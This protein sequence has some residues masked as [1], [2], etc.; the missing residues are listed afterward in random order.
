MR[1]VE[2]QVDERGGGDPGDERADRAEPRDDAADRA[3]E[4]LAPQPERALEEDDPDGDR[5]RV[6]EGGTEERLRVDQLEDVPREDADEQQRDDRRDDE[7]GGEQLRA[8]CEDDDE[9]QPE[10][11]VIHGGRPSDGEDQSSSA[12]VSRSFASSSPDRF[13]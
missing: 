5:D 2:Q 10:Q 8:D 9:R 1:H 6:G 3:R 4:L 11:L 13:V 7:P 12:N